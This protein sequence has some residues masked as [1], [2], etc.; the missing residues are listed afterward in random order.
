MSSPR[1]WWQTESYLSSLIWFFIT[2]LSSVYVGILL[3]AN[4]CSYNSST[5]YA[6]GFSINNHFS[7]A[8]AEFRQHCCWEGW[9]GTPCLLQVKFLL[10][11]Q[12]SWCINNNWHVVSTPTLFSVDQNL[13][14][15]QTVKHLITRNYL[16]IFAM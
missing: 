7:V 10:I 4:L 6:E 16:L 3:H 2:S 11:P 14:Q 13:R 9:C 12:E 15:F 1:R 5:F 8:T